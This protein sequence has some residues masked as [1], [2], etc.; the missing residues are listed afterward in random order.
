MKNLK[1]INK[2]FYKY[3]KELIL[4]I[5]ITIVARIFALVMPEY[6]QKAMDSIQKYV[7]GE[8]L[9]EGKSIEYHLLMCIL[10]IVVSAILSGFFTFLMRQLIINVSRY[11]EF[12]MKNEVFKKYQSLSQKF[13]KENRTG[14][15]MSRISEDVGKVRMYAGPALM[16]GVQTITLFLCIVPMMIYS[17]KILTFYTLLPLPFLAVLIYFISK[18]INVKTKEVQEFLS[19]ISTF[20]QETFSGVNVIK[21]FS[22]EEIYFEKNKNI[23][24]IGKK[25]ALSLAKVDAWF[26]PAMT[27]L[28]GLS[29]ILVVFIGGKLFIEG[30]IDSIGVIAKF[31]IYVLM[32]TWPVSSIGWISSMTQQ[33]EASQKR[34]NEFLSVE[35]EIFSEK[36]ISDKKI[37]GNIKFDNISF[38]YPDTQIKALKNISFEIKQGQTILILGKTGSGKSTIVELLSRM[39][40]PTQGEIF[41]EGIPIKDFNL[42]YLRS[43]ISV[44]PQ[45]VFLFSDTIENNI[46][47]GNESADSQKVEWAA[48]LANVHQNIIDFK[49][50]YQ[51]VLGERGV[52]LSG[53]QKQRVSI[54]RCLIKPAE[55]YIFDD[56]LS[57]VDTE[58]EEKILTNIHNEFKDKTKIFV[59]HRISKNQNPDLILMLEDGF[60]KEIGTPEALLNQK[61][62]Y[63]EYINNHFE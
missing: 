44:V 62:V 33:A 38:E 10:I 9:I 32:L 58:T 31:S 54:A 16:Y 11:I 47:F 49:D 46:L 5:F 37:T 57:A 60:L 35:Q 14:D 42:N 56:C 3:K 48:K 22:L 7:E 55:I 2:Y 6:V 39:Y 18:K 19:D 43:Q 63:W 45:E 21:S 1:H 34:I 4:G 15:L 13:Y 20:S 27:F 8:N 17:S 51:T 28:I 50:H 12:D 23:T 25:K 24:E 29:V 40:N 61:G 41:I 53:G 36:N 30:K 26:V 52:S 59:T